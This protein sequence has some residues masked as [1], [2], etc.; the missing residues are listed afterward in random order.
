MCFLG[1]LVFFVPA[2][3]GQGL[4][5][6]QVIGFQSACSIHP[7]PSSL[8]N[9]IACWL[10]LELHSLWVLI[11]YVLLARCLPEYLSFFRCGP[12]RQIAPK[13]QEFST[14]YPKAVFL[15]VDV[16]QCQVRMQ[17]SLTLIFI[18]V[19]VC[20][21][22]SLYVCVCVYHCMYLCV[23]VCMYMFVFVH[24]CV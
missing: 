23:C 10:L 20:L 11:F 15:K 17:G 8:G 24:M 3:P 7:S 16:D 19:C 9:L 12:C 2:D 21:S 22:V 14:A 4:F 13:F 18:C 6:V 5:V 1:G